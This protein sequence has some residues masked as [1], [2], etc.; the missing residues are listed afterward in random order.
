M[1]KISAIVGSLAALAL[2]TA[3]VLARNSDARPTDE[4]PILSS[5]HS[6]QPGPDGNWIEIPCQELG[7]PAQ[8]PRKPEG[9]SAEQTGH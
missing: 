7:S 1:R 3:P 9:R 6:L 8:P 5:C 4:K 2:L